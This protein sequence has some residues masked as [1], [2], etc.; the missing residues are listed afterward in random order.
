[1]SS[2]HHPSHPSSDPFPFP[3][4]SAYQS[5]SLNHRPQS[6]QSSAAAS[7]IAS[8]STHTPAGSN[9]TAPYPHPLPPSHHH[10]ATQAAQ[11]TAPLNYQSFHNHHNHPHHHHAHPYS[12]SFSQSYD[13]FHNAHPNHT[14]NNNNRQVARVPRRIWR[15]VLETQPRPYEGQKKSKVVDQERLWAQSEVRDGEGFER[16]CYRLKDWERRDEELGTK[17][18]FKHIDRGYHIFLSSSCEAIP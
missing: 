12:N 4:Q 15:R 5:Q 7:P 6:L 11:L 10:P 13:H 1:M 14:N 16:R 8:S 18:T 17:F 9:V 3:P 2:P